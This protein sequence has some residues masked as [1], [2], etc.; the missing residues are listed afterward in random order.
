MASNICLDFSSESDYSESEYSDFCVD[1]FNEAN[2]IDGNMQPYS[3]EPE[4]SF[5]IIYKLFYIQ[6][7][8][9]LQHLSSK[10]F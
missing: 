4:V 9:C 8:M 6:V 1:E 3:G 2:I 10:C 7:M 5:N